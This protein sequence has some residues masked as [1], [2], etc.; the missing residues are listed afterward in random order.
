M[1]VSMSK[2]LSMSLNG[3]YNRGNTLIENSKNME[4]DLMTVIM[5]E[6]IPYAESLF[7][8][9]NWTISFKKSISSMECYDI[10][11][12]NGNNSAFPD[13]PDILKDDYAKSY[14]SPDG[15]ILFAVTDTGNKIP[16]LVSEDKTQGTNDKLFAENKKRQSTGN[17]IERA[18]KNINLAKTLCT[19]L[20][21]FP[22]ILFATGCDF[23]HSESISMRLVQMNYLQPNHYI[24]IGNKDMT[25]EQQLIN[26]ADN[27]NIVKRNGLDI[28]TICIK[29]HKW[30]EYPNGSSNWTQS[31]RT[32]L[33]K[34]VIDQV[35]KQLVQQYNL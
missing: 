30:N 2:S 8:R 35:F 33:C 1:S 4:Y 20:S 11:K 7:K 26:I 23:H 17:A 24:D 14:M 27:V 16:I 31:E 29:A 21:Y 15:G 12:S 28:A 32:M 34:I 9:Y 25:I 3:L 6:I 18:A 13:V 10:F 22:Y 19:D 5:G